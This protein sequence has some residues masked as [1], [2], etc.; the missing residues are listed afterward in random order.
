MEVIVNISNPIYLSVSSIND[1]RRR[2]LTLLEQERLKKIPKLKSEIFKPKINQSKK[3]LDYKANIVNKLSG[4]FY[5]DL[6][7]EEIEPGF[8]LVNDNTEKSLMTCK[9]CIKDELGFCPRNSDKSLE[10]PLYLVQQNKKYKLV[11]N[12]KDCFMEIT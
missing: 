3:Q 7:A 6:G 9:Y 11:F 4:E 1:L 10:E 8:E 5:K 2:L 12:C